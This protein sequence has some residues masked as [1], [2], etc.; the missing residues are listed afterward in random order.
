MFK[1]V[2]CSFFFINETSGG[3]VSNGVRGP[4]HCAAAPFIMTDVSIN[5]DA[6]PMTAAP[7]VDP[8]FN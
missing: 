6:A 5:T 3:G 2:A 4:A 7:E 1:S 8:L